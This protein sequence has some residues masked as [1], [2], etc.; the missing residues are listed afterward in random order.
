MVISKKNSGR[1]ENKPFLIGKIVLSVLAITSL[2]FVNAQSISKQVFATAGNSLSNANHILTSTIGESMVGKIQN[3][4]I[5]SQG[6]LATASIDNT[7]SIDD[8]LLSDTLKVYPNPVTENLH[9]DFTNVFGEVKISIYSTSGQLVRTKVLK[10]QNNKLNIKELQHG[11]YLM[12]LH[13]VDY[14]TF[15]SFK[16][17]KK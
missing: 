15:R 14:K 4:T 5:I 10:S 6:F 17:I 13:F 9:I 1:Y 7:L 3:T 8:L 2:G 11:L 12:N 16:I